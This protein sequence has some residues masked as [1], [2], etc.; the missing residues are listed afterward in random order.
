MNLLFASN[1]SL[2]EF[3][4]QSKVKNCLHFYIFDTVNVTVILIWQ[5]VR[6]HLIKRIVP[7]NNKIRRGNLKFHI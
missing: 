5:R 2:K 6:V 7:Y 3:A 1:S 4:L